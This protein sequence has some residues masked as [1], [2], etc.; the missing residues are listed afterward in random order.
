MKALLAGVL[1]LA[2]LLV[3]R[4]ARACDCLTAEP[5]PAAARAQLATVI[6]GRVLAV[7]SAPGGGDPRVDL[8]VIRAWKGATAGAVVTL[9]VDASSCGY[10]AV[11]GD[12]LLIYAP[13]GRAVQQCAGADTA[14]VRW[15]ADI[16]TDAK[17]LGPPTSAA[18]APGAIAGL[19]TDVVVEGTVT[20]SDAGPRPRF[21]LR[22]TRVTRGAVRRQTLRVISSTGACAITAPAVGRKVALRATRVGGEL[23]VSAC[24]ATTGVRA[25]AERQRGYS[26]SSR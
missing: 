4:P 26:R 21:E 8:F 16:D 5:E 24:A 18:A 3:H 15:G 13:A 14:R 7:R 25:L 11:P 6:H 2:A 19:A 9:P 1:A 20:F 23:L 10:F 12:D 17:A 22:A